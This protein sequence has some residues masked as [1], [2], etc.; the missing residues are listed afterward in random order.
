[1]NI[2]NNLKYGIE[3]RKVSSIRGGWKDENDSS[4]PEYMIQI[5]DNSILNKIN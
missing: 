3:I 5:K 4:L 1:M 2:E